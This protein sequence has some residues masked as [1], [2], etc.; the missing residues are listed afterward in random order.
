MCRMDATITSPGA[1][2]S[3]ALLHFNYIIFNF[4]T[5][6]V[7]K[8]GSFFGR[9]IVS[10]EDDVVADKEELRLS[11]SSERERRDLTLYESIMWFLR[12][13]LGNT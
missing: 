4:V 10:Y 7:S 8:C 5:F 12:S 11:K 9:M 13:V 3:N 6:V 2:K 1:L